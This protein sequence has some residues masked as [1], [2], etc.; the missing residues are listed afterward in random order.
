MEAVLDEEDIWNL[1]HEH[2]PISF[3]RS[4][5][6]LCDIDNDIHRSILCSWSILDL[7]CQSPRFGRRNSTQL[8]NSCA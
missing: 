2:R 3:L 8:I 1:E 5:H 4:D 7:V 6:L